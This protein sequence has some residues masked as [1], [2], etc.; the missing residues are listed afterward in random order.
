MR[1]KIILIITCSLA[2]IFLG[3]LKMSPPN[4]QGTGIREIRKLK[5][6]YSVNQVHQLLGV[7][8]TESGSGYYSCTYNLAN[9]RYSYAVLVFEDQLSEIQLYDDKGNMTVL[10][11]DVLPL[12]EREPVRIQQEL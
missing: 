12:S 11:L 9:S 6:G 3:Y 8:T 10:E 4:D 5:V 1:F 2:I 7:P